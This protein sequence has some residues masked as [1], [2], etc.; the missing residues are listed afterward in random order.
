MGDFATELT[1]SRGTTLAAA[2]PRAESG[3]V[4]R[5]RGGILGGGLGMGSGMSWASFLGEVLEHVPELQWKGGGRGSVSTYHMMRN[6][7]QVQG[8]FLG[9]TYPI[10]RYNWMI[11]PNG[12]KAA[13]VKKISEDY[14]LPIRG[15]ED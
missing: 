4:D 2:P 6:D 1:R 9:T 7:A 13:I 8:L 5:D 3:A 12:A 10:R 14:N 11:E 15:K